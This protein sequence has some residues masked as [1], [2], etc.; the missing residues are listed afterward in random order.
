MSSLFVPISDPSLSPLLAEALQL[1]RLS[2]QSLDTD[3]ELHQRRQERFRQLQADLSHFFHPI[4]QDPVS[5]E[6]I[7]QRVRQCFVKALLMMDRKLQLG[8]LGWQGTFPSPTLARYRPDPFLIPTQDHSLKLLGQTFGLTETEI[9]QLQHQLQS[10]DRRIDEQ[11]QIIRAVLT[12]VLADPDHPLPLF[13]HLFGPLPL[14]AAALTWIYTDTQIYFCLDY[15]GTRLRDLDLWH[16]L[17]DSDQMAISRFLSRLQDSDFERFNRFPLFGPCQITQI[18]P[19]WC[20][21]LAHHTGI[22]PDRIRSALVGSISLIP[23]EKAEAFLIHDIWGHYWQWMLT[24]FESDYAILATCDQTLRAAETAYTSDGPLSCREIFHRDGDRVE[25][26]P[27]RAR[28]FFRGEVQQ[29]LGF[30][31]THLL[32]EMVAD[33]AE[34]KFIADYPHAVEDLP[35]SSL[36]KTHPTKLDLSLGDL[37]YLFLRILRPLLE[38]SISALEDSPLEQDLLQDWLQSGETG[39]AIL[40]IQLKQAIAQLG[41]IWLAEYQQA[42]LPQIQ[43]E[44]SL[45]TQLVVNLLYLQNGINRLCTDGSQLSGS[46]ASTPPFRDLM[47]V[48]I[49]CYCS[50]DSYAE[51]WEIDDVLAAYFLPC[52]HHLHQVIGATSALVRT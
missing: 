13:H 1:A 2:T 34:F 5:L 25:V 24:Q 15:Q 33:M 18:D 6:D 43:T 30:L 36:F 35:S 52:W 23:A 46:V 14:P 47:Q 16:S 21:A 50:S 7:P 45:F 39:S 44:N 12:E 37:D 4:R 42:Y 29:R 31:L 22:A 8:G 20:Q 10:I 28:L 38:F 49:G 41:Q 11:K 26:D 17:S 9:A 32:G 51:F 19:Q 3:P 27:E 48:F 40:R